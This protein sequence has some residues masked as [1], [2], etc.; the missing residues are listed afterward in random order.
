MRAQQKN[1]R[2]R[3]VIGV[4]GCAIG[5]AFTG[6]AQAD[7]RYWMWQFSTV[8]ETYFNGAFGGGQYWHGFQVPGA[9]DTILFSAGGSAPGFPPPP[10]DN[11]FGS[12]PRTV[13]FGDF[14]YH[15]FLSGV[16]SHLDAVNATV[17]RVV[18][19]N[20]DYEFNFGSG[21][22][23]FAPVFPGPSEGSLRVTAQTWIGDLEDESASLAIREGT[24][25]S[26]GVVHVASGY[27]SI[28]TVDVRGETARWN[29]GA[30]M[31]LGWVGHGT[32]NV[33]DGARVTVAN[34]IGAGIRDGARGS[35]NVSGGGFLSAPFI[36]L[37]TGHESTGGAH[38]SLSLVGDG[39]RLEAA[40]LFVGATGSAEARVWNGGQLVVSE[41][42][43]V[44]SSAERGS[45]LVVSG[46]EVSAHW[47]RIGTIGDRLNNT[48]FVGGSS[49]PSTVS[50]ADD[51]VVGDRQAGGQLN[52]GIHGLVNSARGYIG[53][54]SSPGGS[55]TITD[56]GAW[57]VTGEMKVG[58][59]QGRG[60]VTVNHG[61]LAV[62][63]LVAIG[64]NGGTGS[65]MVQNGGSLRAGD[66]AVASFGAG[67]VG[68]LIASGTGTAVDSDF[69]I[70][71]GAGPGGASQGSVS[72]SDHAVLSARDALNVGFTSQG[73]LSIAGGG[74]ARS[75]SGRVGRVAGSEGTVEVSG[76]GSRWAVA[77]TLHVGGH[78]STGPGGSGTVE[79]RS[80]G[81]IT[82]GTT[83]ETWSRGTV[84]VRSE[85]R[86]L[87]GPGDV[88]LVAPGTVRVVPG[89]TLAGDGRI[90]GTVVNAGGT[91]SPGH[92]A[93]TLFI[94]DALIAGPGSTLLM[95][96][97]G[98][99]IGAYDQINLV[100]ASNVTLD[101]LLRLTFVDSFA[102]R[103]GD[104]FHIL[105]MGG[106]TV[107]SGAF[108]AVDVENLL[109]GW[110]YSIR[111]DDA[112]H[113]LQVV[114]LSDGVYVPAPSA[115]NTLGV[116]G[117]A[118]ARR[119]R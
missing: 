25:N 70:S 29:L 57:N 112:T 26:G 41:L 96:I 85:G 40:N 30:Y 9:A 109:P 102:P 44:G 52:V 111:L 87:V 116:F 105:V 51:I 4:A 68:S 23:G 37:G 67:T 31:D 35:V 114:S 71:I 95:E 81:L 22:G 77:S 90:L 115:L 80:E 78:S 72:V 18:V 61:D 5:L 12:N 55:V 119:R 69:T 92:S 97:G 46:G 43:R 82:V 20:G 106:S 39:S 84:D 108:A 89:G 63:G 27:R 7:D 65:V 16:H 32:L 74:T 45:E 107:Y 56:D 1:V 53:V 58:W 42:L 64:E 118:A 83:L 110:S 3:R 91:I 8:H 24:L 11:P 86:I 14:N 94:D 49:G 28:G 88:D 99:G 2:A 98:A 73:S 48:C 104:V 103:T 36:A 38:G 66:L 79:A 47:L 59:H 76:A 6:S 100:S 19:H 33:A 101:G 17:E 21:A 50:I 113:T 34:A 93:G 13:Y 10:P 54:A 117:L 75:A 62:G 60:S 15:S